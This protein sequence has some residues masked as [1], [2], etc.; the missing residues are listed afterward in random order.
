MNGTKNKQIREIKKRKIE[1][2]YNFS[3]FKEE[4]IKISDIPIKT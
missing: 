3:E 4:N 2:L 1:Y